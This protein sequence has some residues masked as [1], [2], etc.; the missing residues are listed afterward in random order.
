MPWAA[1]CPSPQL[2]HELGAAG[3]RGF[4]L[5]GL[6]DLALP[7]APTNAH[8]HSEIHGHGTNSDN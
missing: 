5:L 7:H 8:R 1:S 2:Q 3:L 4:S 6:V